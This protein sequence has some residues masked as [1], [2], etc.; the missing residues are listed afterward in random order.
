MTIATAYLLGGLSGLLIVGLIKLLLPDPDD[1]IQETLFR[2][3]VREIAQQTFK[4]EWAMRELLLHHEIRQTIKE[5]LGKEA[6]K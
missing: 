1:R 6:N 2:A 5:E 4:T 3:R